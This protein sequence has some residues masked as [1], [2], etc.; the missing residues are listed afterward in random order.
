M[1]IIFGIKTKYM[2]VYVCVYINIV[3]A[4][5]CYGVFFDRT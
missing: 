1:L 4:F 3:T 5:C 2:Y